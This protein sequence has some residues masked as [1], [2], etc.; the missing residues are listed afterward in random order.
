MATILKGSKS[1]T[2][3][4]KY[5]DRPAPPRLPKY[6]TEAEPVAM[7]SVVDLFL[8]ADR[9]QRNPS[10]WFVQGNPGQRCDT[11]MFRRSLK[12]LP[13][14]LENPEDTDPPGLIVPP[15]AE[16]LVFDL[17]SWDWP[18]GYGQGDPPELLAE[19]IVDVLCRQLGRP[20]T[21]A[22]VAFSG[23]HVFKG[24]RAKVLFQP[25]APVPWAQAKALYQ[26]AGSDTSLI[27]PALPVYFAP[28]VLAENVVDPLPNGRVFVVIRTDETLDVKPAS[29]D[30]APATWEAL[31]RA[32]TAM[33]KVR[34]GEPRHPIVNRLAFQCAGIAAGE[35][36]P[37]EAVV[38]YLIA[39]CE[40]IPVFSGRNFDDEIQRGAQD[41][42]AQP[43]RPL[44]DALMVSGK[45]EIKPTM[46]NAAILL[47][48]ETKFLENDFG[49]QQIVNPPPWDLQG[50][51]YPQ[52]VEE[53]QLRRALAWLQATHRTAF[54]KSDVSDAIGMLAGG[55]RV[56]RLTSYL[57]YCRGLDAGPVTLE[58]AA[59]ACWSAPLETAYVLSVRRFLLQCVAR[60][61][62][63]GCQAELVLVLHGSPGSGKGR[64]AWQLFTRPGPRY[65]TSSHISIGNQAQH[66]PILRGLWGAELGEQRAVSAW[67]KD[68]FKAFV[69]MRKILYRSP[70]DRRASEI[71]LR[72]NYVWTT[73]HET[74]LTD[75]NWR[76]FLV[77]PVK[78]WRE[79][80]GRVIDQLWGAAVRAL[81][82]G[83]RA[84][85]NEEDEA[86]LKPIREAA[87]E[88]DSLEPH[89]EEILRSPDLEGD[90]RAI[91]TVIRTLAMRNHF[92]VKISDS[93][94][95]HR[96]GVI[97]SRLGWTSQPKW[98]KS[99]KIQR[100]YQPPEGWKFNQYAQVAPIT[101]AY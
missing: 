24:C 39:A 34:D 72:V 28:P 45:G 21:S 33:A 88:I 1:K 7:S 52:N 80:S 97:M 84:Y 35:G 68:I 87:Y 5:L 12:V 94:I 89:V 58:N 61:F 92:G 77:V 83:E 51:D 22:V 53:Y 6:W 46:S 32:R 96:V 49:D 18:A 42:Y 20:P 2:L 47:S 50:G 66:A 11:G 17:D 91:D 101:Q 9:L 100:E 79:L 37:V 99:G 71:P 44:E 40:Q 56:N 81:D 4:V 90:V 8:L 95:R 41:G 31:H 93:T 3:A 76:R 70:Y 64:S 15:A 14:K 69:S 74:P 86:V 85:L 36:A 13:K 63:P 19:V 65:F 82:A 59:E 29:G 43:I 16:L 54:K 27:N 48:R 78:R 98:Q 67:H 10:E 60:A 57:T 55:N 75:D 25:S 26:R 23:N 73:E 62:Y 38:D 30:E